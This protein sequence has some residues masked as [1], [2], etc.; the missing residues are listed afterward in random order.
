[1]NGVRF[2]C[3]K[4]GTRMLADISKLLPSFSHLSLIRYASPASCCKHGEDTAVPGCIHCS[5]H[6]ASALASCFAASTVSQRDKGDFLRNLCGNEDAMQAITL[7]QKLHVPSHTNHVIAN[8]KDAGFNMIQPS[9]IQEAHEMIPHAAG[10]QT[11]GSRCSQDC[12]PCSIVFA[13][14]A[15]GPAVRTLLNLSAGMRNSKKD[16]Y[17][18]TTQCQ[19]CTTSR[20]FDRVDAMH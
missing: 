1:M 8:C 15:A 7:V 9:L 11:S 2:W 17:S 12:R 16:A 4:T 20:V 19:C 5:K 13:K 3:C 6:P 14:S 10:Q 18:S